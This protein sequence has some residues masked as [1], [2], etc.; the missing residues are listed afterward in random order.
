MVDKKADNKLR[1]MVDKQSERKADNK[2]NFRSMAD[3]QAE[4]KVIDDKLNFK[5]LAGKQAEKKPGNKLNF[6]S[7][8]AK[9]LEKNEDNESE[10]K[11]SNRDKF[12]LL[13]D[14]SY[15]L[16]DAIRDR[17][18][19]INRLR[20]ELY[21][22]RPGVDE[23]RYTL[24]EFEKETEYI[25]GTE[26]HL[27]SQLTE[28][29]TAK[30]KE[31]KA[32]SNLKS[33]I[34]IIEDEVKDFDQQVKDYHD[35][36]DQIKEDI[37]NQRKAITELDEQYYSTHE[38]SEIE[39]RLYYANDKKRVFESELERNNRRVTS[40]R[41]IFDRLNKQR[42]DREQEHNIDDD[43]NRVKA[44]EAKIDS[45]ETKIRGDLNEID[46]LVDERNDLHR[47]ADEADAKLR[48][49]RSHLESLKHNSQI[50]EAD[51]KCLRNDLTKLA[52]RD[53][54]KYS[55]ALHL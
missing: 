28:V 7:L 19:E 55:K 39:R 42:T 36:I 41:E 12:Y 26:A 53:E 29:T 17:E 3:K 30:D 48:E 25:Q 37:W 18:N 23:K 13:R 51:N 11:E 31:V 44:L 43:E 52:E 21:D 5:Y 27:T 6:N 22:Y 10:N 32:Q 24:S 54:G 45:L 34:T 4:R 33:K 50:L 38:L 47:H 49:T 35:Q 15:T 20:E 9:K 8:A 2:L 46:T 40:L 1:S 14:D 16:E